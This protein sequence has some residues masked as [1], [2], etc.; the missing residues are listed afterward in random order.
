MI[1]TAVGWAGLVGVL[2]LVA[3]C[4]SSDDRPPHEDE[5][6]GGPGLP[7]RAR[8][9]AA[10][11]LARDCFTGDLPRGY[12]A[13]CGEVRVPEG[14]ADARDIELAV[15]ILYSNRDVPDD[16]V[17]YLEGG[18]G[19]SAVSLAWYDPFPFEHI[20]EHRDLVL[21]DQRGTGYSEPSLRC[22]VGSG[23][24]D[25]EIDDVAECQRDWEQQG[26]DL[27]Q[28]NTRQNARDLDRVRQALGFDQWNLYGISY[29]SRLALTVARDYPDTVR[30]MA[31]DGILPLDADLLGD[32]VASMATSLESVSAACL[33]QPDCAETYGDIAESMFQVV[34]QLEAEPAELDG[35][36]QLSGGLALS[37]IVQLLYSAEILPYIPALI[38]G[39]HAEE[40]SLFHELLEGSEAGPG[41]AVGMYYAVTCQDEA[42]FT[43]PALVDAKRAGFDERY[44]L[45]F[46]AQL[47]LAICERWNLPASPE[48]E[49]QRVESDVPSLVT[50][51]AFDPVTPPAYGDM[52]AAGLSNA[53][54]FVLADQSHGASVSSCGNRLVTAFF[55]DPERTLDSG[56][57]DSLGVPDFRTGRQPLVHTPKL[58]FEVPVHWNDELLQKLADAAAR[59]RRGPLRQPAALDR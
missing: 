17:V 5:P 39:L 15:M 45:A 58:R 8:D 51:G 23:S 49:N 27:S 26:V 41:F 10:N 37:I 28:Y 7:Q 2:G 12:A 25:G 31:I 16:P 3:A 14:G 47:L 50:S 59:A 33:A 53:Q 38:A 44:A 54:T 34:D 11:F 42:P 4:G 35:G 52:A 55:N 36:Q 48:R 40:Y 1:R 21:V 43:S 57:V 24:S 6:G 30:S 13:E 22:N 19:A 46:D 32:G 9:K 56:C 18:P 20:L 29:G